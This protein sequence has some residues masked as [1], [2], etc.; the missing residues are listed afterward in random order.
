VVSSLPKASEVRLAADALS[1]SLQPGRMAGGHRVQV[2]CGGGEAYPAML[3]A[4]ASARRSIDLETYIL[5]DDRTGRRF[6]QALAEKARAGVAVRCVIDGAG[7]YELDSALLDPMVEAGVQLEV[8]H[9]VGPWRAH[10]GWSVRDH[11]KLL[12]VDG[13]LAFAGGLNLGDE[14][15]P[16]EEP[17]RG[18][19]WRD[20]GVRVEG[21]V[22]A[23]LQKLFDSTFRH[24]AP[25][26]RLLPPLAP[27]ARF[28]G[29]ARAQALA[30]GR[31][32][33]RKQ[34]QNHY[35]YAVHTAK[36]SV[37]IQSAYFIPNRSWRRALVAAAG[38]GCDVRVM[39]PLHSDV[40]GIRW[41]SQYTW[42]RLLRGGVHLLEFLPT[43]LHSKTVL[44]DDEW[45]AI[46][47]YN[48]DQRSLSYNLEVALAIVDRAVCAALRE[49]FE[50]DARESQEV[51]RDLWEKR[52]TFQRLK[53]KLVYFFRL[54]L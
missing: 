3:E 54:W 27:S 29:E 2:L 21:P 37:L 39:V 4:I 7:S 34:I 47:S 25:A 33:D 23:E 35:L 42:T 43:M 45:A 14:Y 24:V 36:K 50:A 6:V 52:G 30:A 53:E 8:F 13:R 11:R 51:D 12:L 5:R 46:G 28:D 31:R 10:W 1:H 44:V 18:G 49:R 22:V 40:P 20:V 15:A 48:L 38:R 26:S 9:P 41:A 17:W 32:R 19:G 16:R